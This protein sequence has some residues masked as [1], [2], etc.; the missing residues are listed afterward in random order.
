MAVLGLCHFAWTISN[1]GERGLFFVAV[2]GLLIEVASLAVEHRLS[3]CGAQ[4][5]F[6]DR[7]SMSAALAGGF[8]STVPPGKSLFLCFFFFFN[9]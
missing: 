5:I 7:G 1:C 8:L 9:V 6:L 2:L 4:G 3:S